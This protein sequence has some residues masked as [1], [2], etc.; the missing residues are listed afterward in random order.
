MDITSSNSFTFK[1]EI[2]GSAYVFTVNCAATEV[3]A[4][5]I[6]RGHLEEFI[7]GLPTA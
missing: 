6:L 1:Q 7:K 5:H 3:E 4:A 2:G